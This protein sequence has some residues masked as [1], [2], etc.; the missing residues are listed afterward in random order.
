V[1]R[2]GEEAGGWF[3]ARFNV[4]STPKYGSW[5]NQAEIEISLFSRQCLGKRRIADIMDLLRQAKAW[6]RHAN[7]D[8]ITIRW[9]FT[10]KQARRKMNYSFTRSQY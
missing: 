1:D 2:F 10:R 9:K 7:S 3:W 6:N 8:H 5:L 4:H